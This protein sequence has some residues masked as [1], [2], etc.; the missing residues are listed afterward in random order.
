MLLLAVVLCCVSR[1]LSLMNWMCAV[2]CVRLLRVPGQVIYSG[3]RKAKKIENKSD[4]DFVTDTDQQSERLILGR[5]RELFPT[6][7]FIGEEETAKAGGVFPELTDAP[8]WF[9]DPLDGTTNF[10]HTFPF[11][12]VCIGLSVEKEV[13]LGKIGQMLFLTGGAVLLC[14]TLYVCA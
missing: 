1:F 2:V 9:C 10:V 11:V 6:H 7:C 5:L 13:V 12:C 4:R 3:F 8:T 14:N